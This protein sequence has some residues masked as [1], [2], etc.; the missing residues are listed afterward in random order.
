MDYIYITKEDNSIEKMEAVTIFNISNSNY[1]YIIYKSLITGDYYAGKYFGDDM[2]DLDTDL[3]SFEIEC[4]SGVFDS[5][6]G[7]V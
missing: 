2:S 3:N 5:L 1:N 4:V 7:E 6:I